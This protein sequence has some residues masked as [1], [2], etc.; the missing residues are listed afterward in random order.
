MILILEEI[1][2]NLEKN[3]NI[4]VLKKLVIKRFFVFFFSLVYI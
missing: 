4:F 2:R 3:L 1:K